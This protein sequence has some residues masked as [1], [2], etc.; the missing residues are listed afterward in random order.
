[1][2]SAWERA[3]LIRRPVQRR[4]AEASLRGWRSARL[5]PP[6][7]RGFGEI[8]TVLVVN[9]D[10]PP[11]VVERRDVRRHAETA[12]DVLYQSSQVGKLELVDDE[13]PEAEC[14]EYAS[15]PLAELAAAFEDPHG[16]ESVFALQSIEVARGEAAVLE[17]MEGEAGI[18]EL[19]KHDLLTG[20]S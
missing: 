16:P 7:E 10:R 9:V 11:R 2:I 8:E 3:R 13:G 19:A 5:A 14:L 12:A 15:V 17:P 20:K 18:G 6:G 4:P 1:M